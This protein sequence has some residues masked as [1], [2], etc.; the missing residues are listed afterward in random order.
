LDPA[1]TNGKLLIDLGF[2]C[3]RHL[4]AVT[5]KAFKS[6]DIVESLKAGDDNPGRV[7]QNSPGSARAIKAGGQYKLQKTDR[8][9]YT[10]VMTSRLDI[11]TVTGTFKTANGTDT[12]IAGFNG[13]LYARDSQS[14]VFAI[15]INEDYLLM[16]LTLTDQAT[17]EVKKYFFFNLAGMDYKELLLD[18]LEAGHSY[19]VGLLWVDMNGNPNIST[20]PD[21]VS[22][23]SAED[24][25]PPVVT[26]QTVVERTETTATLHVVTNELLRKMKVQYRIAGTDEWM[27]Q[28][29]L[30]TNTIYQPLLEGLLTG[31]SYEYRY[32]LEDLSGNQLITDWEVF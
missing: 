26:E 5:S 21:T 29:I 4:D 13:S 16:E 3:C 14:L 17:Q 20:S 32:I 25:I 27:E 18:G 15:R 19:T 28:V 8:S 12:V 2:S 24:E 7:A 1:T 9:P 22:T 31:A 30:E 11:P 23:G 6:G 10:L